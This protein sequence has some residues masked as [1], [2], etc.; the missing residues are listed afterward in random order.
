MRA[1]QVPCGRAA[2]DLAATETP[3]SR[4]D[5][6]L[7]EAMIERAPA[8]PRLKTIRAADIA[9]VSVSWLWHGW[10]PFGKLVSIDGA[11][12]IGKSTVAIDLIARATLGG[13]MPHSTTTFTPITV[14]IAGVEDG[15]ADTV[16]PRLEAA[17]ADL[18]RVHFVDVRERGTRSV[19]LPDD[20]V[21]L[22]ATARE[23][24]AKWLHIDAIMGAL[25]ETVS[26][27]SDHEVR[28]ALGPVCNLAETDGVL[29]TFIRHPRKAGG[30][31]VNAGGGSVAFGALARMVLFAG[32]DPGDASEDPN[33]RRRVLAVAKSNLA[34]MP[35]AL[36]FAVVDAANGMGCIGWG[37]ASNLSA[38]DLAAPQML[39]SRKTIDSVR[40]A[41]QRSEAE[42][43]LERLLAD[44]ARL[45]VDEVKGHSREKGLSF[46]TVERAATS[47]GVVKRRGGFHAPSQ[48]FLPAAPGVD[49]AVPPIP[50]SALALEEGGGT[51]GTVTTKAQLTI[52]TTERS[53]GD[54]G[55]EVAA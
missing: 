7:L 43:F 15:W 49:D 30:S 25:S 37:D 18:N 21:E 9:T 3:K 5:L 13:P 8:R 36:T 12:G 48:W 45:S 54:A 24:G 41:T 29:V 1:D 27:Y 28:R 20:V 26:A 46:R 34:K 52:D 39:P 33:M 2:Q 53:R 17:G 23:L 16:R 44:G 22:A 11:P 55:T 38:D 32:F 40:P 31:G 51:G 6:A 4:E 50:P 35:S 42:L 19:T 10:L 47:I 14:M